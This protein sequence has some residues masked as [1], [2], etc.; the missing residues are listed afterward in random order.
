[1][2]HCDTGV[3]RYSRGRVQQ[4]HK[5]TMPI[6]R[7]ELLLL[8]GTHASPD[9]QEPPL[10][11]SSRFQLR[12]TKTVVVNL[13]HV[14][15]SWLS[16]IIKSSERFAITGLRALRFSTTA[17]EAP[18]GTESLSAPSLQEWLPELSCGWARF[19]SPRKRDPY[20]N[21]EVSRSR[22]AMLASLAAASPCWAGLAVLLTREDSDRRAL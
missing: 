9:G 21:S 3:T 17:Q 11:C 15:H 19:T 12:R 5:F 10:V 4:M 20:L 13:W 1:M 6:A 22:A 8:C 14:C 18:G 2:H 16:V 7:V